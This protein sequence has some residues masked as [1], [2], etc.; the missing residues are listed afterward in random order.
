MLYGLYA[1]THIQV[2]LGPTAVT[3]PVSIHRGSCEPTAIHLARTDVPGQ[4]RVIWQSAVKE[5][6]LRWKLPTT[7]TTT[8]PSPPPWVAAGAAAAAAASAAA[9]WQFVASTKTTYT[10]DKLCG[11]PVSVS[12]TATS[13][14]KQCLHDFSFFFLLYTCSDVDAQWVMRLLPLKANMNIGVHI[15]LTAPCSMT[16]SLHYL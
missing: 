6:V 2:A 12:H 3:K 16:L 11:Q 1:R 14:R 5:G 10:Q 8:P 9:E 15:T 7:T 13:L 4:Y